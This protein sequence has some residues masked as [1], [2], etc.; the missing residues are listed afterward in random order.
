MLT[1][2]QQSSSYIAKHCSVIFCNPNF[3]ANESILLYHKLLII[4]TTLTPIIIYN[5]YKY[6]VNKY[7]YYQYSAG[8][9][10]GKLEIFTKIFKICKHILQL[11]WISDSNV[12][13]TTITFLMPQL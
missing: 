5:I 3:Y 7:N 13:V 6:E 1:T 2:K 12:K 11:F 10:I 4:A 8:I 9:F